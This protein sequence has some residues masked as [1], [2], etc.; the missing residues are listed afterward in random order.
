MKELIFP[1]AFSVVATDARARPTAA[2]NKGFVATSSTSLVWG[3]ILS[4]ALFSRL[5]LALSSVL[6]FLPLLFLCASRCRQETTKRAREEGLERERKEKLQGEDKGRGFLLTWINIIPQWA[7]EHFAWRHMWQMPP[8]VTQ[9]RWV[10]YKRL[11][12]RRVGCFTHRTPSAT[13]CQAVKSSVVSSR[14]ALLTWVSFSRLTHRD[15]CRVHF[16][17]STW[18]C[19]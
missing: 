15:T 8:A 10:A 1:P 19:T 12:P 4:L 6:S 7:A 17:T 14:C 2:T 11:A 3:G 9:G 16:E 18:T 5:A 13:F